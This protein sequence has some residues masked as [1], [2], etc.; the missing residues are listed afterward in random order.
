MI[1]TSQGIVGITEMIAGETTA[2]GIETEGLWISS[3]AFN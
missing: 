1:D 2:G 3:F